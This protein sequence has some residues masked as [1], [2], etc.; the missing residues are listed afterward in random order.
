MAFTAVKSTSIKL[1]IKP[2][3]APVPDISG[4]WLHQSGAQLRGLTSEL[5]HASFSRLWRAFMTA[6]VLIAV[7]LLLLQAFIY[8]LTNT[9][10]RWSLAVCLG[11]LGA[12]LAVRLIAQPRP[13]SS[14]FGLQW[15]LT[16]GI[17][18]LA[19]TTLNFL[20]S[21]AI[22]YTPLFALPVLLA[23]VLGPIL[24]ALGTAAAVTI[25]LLADAWWLSIQVAGDASAKFLQAGLS[26][27]GFFAVALLANQ[28]SLRL[29][30]E[31]QLSSTSQAVARTQT[32]VNELVVETLADGVLVI[33]ANGIVRSANPAARRLLAKTDLVKMA[34]FVLATESAWQPLVEVMRKTF[35]ERQALEVDITLLHVGRSPKRL[36]ARTRL[37]SALGYSGDALCVMFLEDLRELEA[38]VRVEK[39]AA[40]G[41]MSAAVAHEIRN[42]LAAISQANELLDEDLQDAGQKRLSEMV[43]QNAQRLSKIVDDILNIARAQAKAPEQMRLALRLDETTSRIAADWMGQTL[44]A[45]LVYL[46]LNAE[47]V[48]IVFDPDHL[49]RVLINLLDNALRYVTPSEQAIQIE[50]HQVPGGVSRLMVWSNGEPLEETVE[51]HL[52]EPFFSS[53]SRSSGLGLYIC[54][55]LCE[56]YGATIGYRRVARRMTA[57]NEFFVI[58]Q[59]AG[60]DRAAQSLQHDDLFS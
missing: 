51:S 33:D 5:R 6:R 14:V 49:R 55:E 31:E 24:L 11:Y 7:V 53:E 48:D 4:S 57:G 13:P 2:A 16:I 30:R 41:R 50:T 42:P 3:P 56:R 35:S 28:L 9:A 43:R 39:M 22:F 19:F 58:F 47:T 29:A 25:F 54:R 37:A 20:Q 23:S 18:V 17:D 44:S 45:S 38:R 32:A 1:A 40:M 34:P 21:S 60:R 46:S 52:F 59:S 36:R 8:V 26:G 10:D 27:T 15:L 12:T